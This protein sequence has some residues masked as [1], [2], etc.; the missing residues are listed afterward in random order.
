M[1]TPTPGQDQTE[2]LNSGLPQELPLSFNGLDVLIVDDDETIRSIVS[3]HLETKGCLTRVAESGEQGLAAFAEQ[4][5][6]VVLLDLKMPGLN[7][8]EVCEQMRATDA[9]RHI[10][11]LILTASDDPESVESAF[12]VGATDF[13]RK[14]LNLDLLV[15]RL[16]FVLRAQ[17]ITDQLRT[18]E[19]NMLQAQRIARMGTWEF[20]LTRRE[21]ICSTV[22]SDVLRVDGDTLHEDAFFSSIH[23]DDRERIETLFDRAL[24]NR[25]S[26]LVEFR[27]L[28]SDGQE[29]VLSLQ[30]WEDRAEH[31]ELVKGSPELAG[32]IKDVTERRQTESR[33]RKLAYYDGT[34]GLPN[35]A[36][37]IEHLEQAAALAK[38]QNHSM[39][40]LLIDLDHFQSINEK[41]GHRI[42]DEVLEEVAARLKSCL[43]STDVVASGAMTAATGTAS[44]KVIARIGGD[45]FVILLSRLRHSE[46]AALVA[47]RVNQAVSAPFQIEHSEVHLGCSIGIS[48]CPD[49]ASDAQVLLKQ[50]DSA[51]YE[52]KRKGRNGFQ[53][54]TSRIHERALK[55]I[56]LEARLRQA[57]QNEQFVLHYQPK[58]NCQTGELVGCEA[59]VRW[60]DPDNGLISP[61]EFIP[62]AE[63]TGLIVPLGQWVIETACRQMKSLHQA[64]GAPLPISVNLSARQLRQSN[65]VEQIARS[66]EVHGLGKQCLELELTESLLIE[67]AEKQITLLHKLKAHGIDLSIDDFGTGYSSL[68]YLKRFPIDTL[69]IDQSFIRDL[70]NDAKDTAIVSAA[71]TLA[72]NLDMQVVAEGVE[73]QAQ[74]D[75][76]AQLNCDVVQGYLHS[77]P[78]PYSQLLAWINQRQPV[79]A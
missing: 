58:I 40:I 6:D 59:L 71:I 43:R 35:R 48:V 2:Q 55:R 67:D 23:P 50:A 53:Y 12:R 18:R 14:P 60:E 68:A 75:L 25:S 33:I 65:L 5:A 8:F 52:A 47:K 20:H 49:D 31:S 21:F 62:L 1:P 61:G 10:P 28:S 69:K 73:T 17:Q 45:E 57:V 4:A 32:V 38:R 16:Q 15:H 63:E 70:E 66:L 7:G 74:H 37:L 41:W 3:A 36:L 22:L 44:R 64:I 76:L 51:M 34:T 56:D 29:S 30:T 77:R 13:V 24:E 46:D 79:S 27:W 19:Q 72:H 54:Y 26:L 39:A 42:G 9:G 11:I 78:L